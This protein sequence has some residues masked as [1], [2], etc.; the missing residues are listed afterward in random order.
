MPE[1]G[2]IAEWRAHRQRQL[3]Q[4]LDDKQALKVH[5]EDK[6]KRGKNHDFLF[7]KEKAKHRKKIEQVVR[8]IEHAKMQLDRISFATLGEEAADEDIAGAADF[9]AE[10]KYEVVN[11]YMMMCR[12]AEAFGCQIRHDLKTFVST[13]EGRAHA[14]L[15][16]A[17]FVYEKDGTGRIALG[18]SVQLREAAARHRSMAAHGRAQLLLLPVLP[19]PVFSG[20]FLEV[21]WIQSAVN[22]SSREQAQ[23]QAK[24]QLQRAELQA[25]RDAELDEKE[26]GRAEEQRQEDEEDEEVE[27]ESP[28]GGYS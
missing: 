24:R 2:G 25:K 1:A 13:H 27:E 22:R 6:F 4:T 19:A 23:F 28:L 16:A 7:K 15:F 5:Y 10:E 14:L 20:S 9:S 17:E 21:P 3:Q 8:A 18:S 11:T 12:A 26:S